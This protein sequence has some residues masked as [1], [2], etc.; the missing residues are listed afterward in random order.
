MRPGRFGWP[1]PA[2]AAGAAAAAFV[3]SLGVVGADAL[4]LVPLGGRVARGAVPAS[5]PYAAAQSSGW[6]NVTVA[7]QLLF[8]AAYH[9][10]GGVRGLV[11]L[12]TVAAAIAV[13]ALAG[14]VRRQATPGAAL[15]VSL[16]VIVGALPELA[17]AN[18]ALFSLALFPILLALLEADGSVASARIWVAVP[19]IAAWANL[20]GAVLAGWALLGCYLLVGRLRRRGESLAVF[21]A[22]T[23]AL[24]L[25]PALWHTPSYYWG[26]FR[27]AAAQR[28]IGLWA[29]LG[30]MPFD[31]LLIVA[32]VAAT[33]AAVRRR[34]FAPWEAVA[35][36]GLAVATVDVARNGVFLLFLL[37]YP[38]ARSLSRAGPRPR[39]L[40]V[41]AAALGAGAVAALIGG[42]PDPGSWSLARVA[43]ES[44]GVVLAE[45][46]LA[47]QVAL[48]GGRVWM[49]NPLD[50][51]RRED[52]RVYV[53][54][55]SGKPGGASAVRH[56]QLVLVRAGS[57]AG[58]RAR[59]DGRLV[60]L[61]AGDGAVVYRVRAAG[62]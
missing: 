30:A 26:V 5:I 21:A 15:M 27:S 55:F 56:A 51:F 24:F 57:A 17:V 7:A 29:H 40:V 36:A 4:W 61:R 32:A 6:R 31:V 19:L 62:R 48:A 34:S 46:V 59:A 23:V 13:G 52:Q 45:P 25:N 33:A 37:A 43:A 10:F 16:L 42:A 53:D 41:A 54:W 44:G 58:K 39:L 47:Q 9:A 8:W 28:H 12:Q 22:A 20:H 1:A 50:A 3:A 35:A 11:V 60:L 18:A 38:A 2:A 49:T 14:G